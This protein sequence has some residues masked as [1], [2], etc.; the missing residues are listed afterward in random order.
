VTIDGPQ[1]IRGLAGSGK[2]VILAMKAA[3]L[4]MTRPND[5]ILV[6]FFTKSLRS[7]IKDLVTKFYRHYKEIDPD[8]NNIHIRHGWGGSNSSGT[9]A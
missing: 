5:K 8:W 2:T 6:T 9:Y 7:P 1:R 4:H 3:H